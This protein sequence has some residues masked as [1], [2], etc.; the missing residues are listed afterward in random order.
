MVRAL[1]GPTSS[2]VLTVEEEVQSSSSIGIWCGGVGR[3]EGIGVVSSF[4]MEIITS[5]LSEVGG[6]VV[7]TGGGWKSGWEVKTAVPKS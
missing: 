3:V 7:V 2:M 6:D 1:V 4:G 5:S